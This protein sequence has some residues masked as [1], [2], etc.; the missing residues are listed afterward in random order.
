MNLDLGSGAIKRQG[1]TSIDINRKLNPDITADI[2]T[3]KP[4]PNKSAHQI[5]CSHTLEH[6]LQRDLFKTLRS[7]HRVLK[8]KGQLTIIVPDIQ[9]VAHD[10]TT[11]KIDSKKFESILLGSDPTATRHMLHKNVFYTEK[12]KRFLQITGFTHIKIKQNNSHYEL[13]ATAI[14]PKC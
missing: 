9:Q 6:I 4:I 14:K 13:I 1:W 7:I 3:L 12:L 2:R 11:K 10:W 8:P 5:L